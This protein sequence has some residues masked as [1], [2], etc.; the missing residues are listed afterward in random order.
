MKESLYLLLY[1]LN[2]NS[3][4]RRNVHKY[5]CHLTS[6]NIRPIQQYVNYNRER[7]DR[8]FVRTFVVYISVCKYTCK[9]VCTFIF[10]LYNGNSCFHIHKSPL[11]LSKH[12]KTSVLSVPSM[13][14]WKYILTPYLINSMISLTISLSFICIF[15]ER[16]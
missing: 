3:T 2:S 12:T 8:Y 1:I 7:T 4:E 15:I 10:R 6:T 11:S 16:N 5:P 13:I 9:A 14:I